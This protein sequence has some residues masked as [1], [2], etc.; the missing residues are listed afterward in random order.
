MSWTQR[1]EG[2]EN[3]VL[4][5]LHSGCLEGTKEVAVMEGVV[6]VPED[7]DEAFRHRKVLLFAHSIGAT[8]LL[9]RWSEGTRIEN[10]KVNCCA[11]GTSGMGR[12]W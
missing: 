4:L 3:R 5:F 6:E 11:G 8:T 10:K 7:L 2:K 9:E 1:H 12:K